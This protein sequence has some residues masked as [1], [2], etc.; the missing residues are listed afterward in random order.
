MATHS[1][2]TYVLIANRF[3]QMKCALNEKRDPQSYYAWI[4]TVRALA[5][6]FK[7]DNPR[8]DYARFYAACGLASK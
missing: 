6:D 7:E 8:F 4:E 1:R 2:K 3:E 5:I